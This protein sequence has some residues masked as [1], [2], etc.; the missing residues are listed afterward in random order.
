MIID[1]HT[2]DHHRTDAI[3]S[4]APTDFHPE[5]GFT[6]SVGIH[7]WSTDQSTDFSI[8][9]QA[10]AHPTVIAIGETG[11]D[12]LRGADTE[13]QKKIFERHILLSEQL[14]KPLIMHVVKAVDEVLAIHKTMKPRMPW[15][16][17]GFRGNAQ[18]ARQLTSKGIYLSLGERFNPKAAEA[19]DS[20][21]LLLESDESMLS[22][23][24]IAERTAASRGEPADDVMLTAARN[25]Q[26]AT[27]YTV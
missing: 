8:L 5:E 20:D 10:A 18:M 19:I 11:I 4:V 2:H 12:R 21:M 9:A 6:Y 3:I 16:W 1:C 13:T 14:H 15:I 24:E 17:H 27:A 25:L 22:I 26:R 7:P 23:R